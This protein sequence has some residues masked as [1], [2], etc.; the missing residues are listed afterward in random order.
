MIT[1]RKG[2]VESLG[3]IEKASYE[4]QG[5]DVLVATDSGPMRGLTAR[6]TITRPG[7]AESAAG[8]MRKVQ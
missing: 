5:K 4:V 7:V 1:F 8:T 6:Y 2:Q 3:L